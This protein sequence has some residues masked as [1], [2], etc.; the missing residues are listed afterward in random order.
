MPEIFSILSSELKGYTDQLAKVYKTDLVA[1]NKELG[2]LKLAQ[3]DPQCEKVAGC[4]A[5]P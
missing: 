3:L 1:V 4:G 5:I 2:R